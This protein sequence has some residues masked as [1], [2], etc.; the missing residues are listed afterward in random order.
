MSECMRELREETLAR[1][2]MLRRNNRIFVLE[3]AD[4]V[5]APYRKYQYAREE[6]DAI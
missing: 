5:R 6:R 4:G 3:R 1:A 2:R